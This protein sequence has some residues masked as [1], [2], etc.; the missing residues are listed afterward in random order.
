LPRRRVDEVRDIL[1]RAVKIEA[2]ARQARD[3]QLEADTV[4]I[5]ECDAM[6]WAGKPAEFAMPGVLVTLAAEADVVLTY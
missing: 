2:Y 4:E 1:D 3:H 5:R 6:D